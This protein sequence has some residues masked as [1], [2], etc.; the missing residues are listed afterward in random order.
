MTG[1]HAVEWT[2]DI[3]GRRFEWGS[4]TYVM[5][6]VNVTPDSFSGDGLAG[7]VDA[8]VLQALAFE[9]QGADIVDVGGES[10][11]PPGSVYGEGAADCVRGRGAG[12]RHARARS[13]AR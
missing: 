11:R 13:A 5:G 8:A 4:R 2:V 10:S 9:A 1:G 12:S 7:D 3:G 6:I